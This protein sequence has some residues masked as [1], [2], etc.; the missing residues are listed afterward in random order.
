MRSTI[1][2]AW[3]GTQRLPPLADDC[4]A[5]RTDPLFKLAVGQS[6]ESGRALCSHL[7]H[8]HLDC[9]IL[10]SAGHAGYPWT[11]EAIAVATKHVS[12]YIDTSAWTAK[13]YEKLARRGRVGANAAAFTEKALGQPRPS[14]Q[15][16][17]GL[18]FPLIAA[19]TSPVRI[20]EHFSS[21]RLVN[22]PE[23]SRD[24]TYRNGPVEHRH[25]LTEYSE[26]GGESGPTIPN[27][28]ALHGLENFVWFALISLSD[29]VIR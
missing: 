20:Y 28:L 17:R 6:P 15:P 27:D 22:L 26:R 2:S 8:V 7:R 25:C 14:L 29:L 11:V 5:L 3:R 10:A 16:D 21:F 23:R 24:S 1:A 4:D 9:A 12:V 19:V 18:V 13:R